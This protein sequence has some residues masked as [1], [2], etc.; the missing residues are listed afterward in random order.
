MF[1]RAAFR[2]Q[3]PV[4]GAFVAR[5]SYSSH[6]LDPAN[7]GDYEAYVNQWLK[8]FSTV[9]DDFELERGLNHIFAADW[10]PSVEVISEALKASRRLNTFATAV[11]ILE[12]LQEKAY[13]AEQYQAYIRELKPI[14]DEYGIPEKKDLGAFEVVRDRNPLME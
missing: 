2:V 6:E 14:L 5:R 4:V 10:V 3:R 7:K 8:H 12:G 9:E 13:K 11:R 1:P